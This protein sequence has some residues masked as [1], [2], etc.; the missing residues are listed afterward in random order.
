[1]SSRLSNP[2]KFLT[3]GARDL[4]ERQRT[5]RGAIAWSH[6][7]LDE[8]E[9]VLFARL[10][11]F[12][13]GCALEA[14]EAICD[15]VGD[16]FVDV[17]E[18]LSSLLD[19]SLL[20]QEEM[21]EEEPRFLMLETIR[22]YALERLELSGE[23]EEIRRLHAEYFLALAERGESKLREPE[24]ATWLERLDT[25]HDNMRAAL[26]WALESEEAELGLKLASSLWQFWDMRG[27][28]GEGRR[29]LR[30]R[31]PRTGEPQG[32]GQRR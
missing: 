21:V 9:Q 32:R 31:W 29:W 2:L 13:D 12:S 6:A 23:A 1:M 27:Y 17:L 26:S 25:E 5:L 7:L 19:G 16:L 20:R 10:S 15:P 14:V 22:E 4:P 3:G 30:R 18:G 11:V 28:Y 8:D 24:E